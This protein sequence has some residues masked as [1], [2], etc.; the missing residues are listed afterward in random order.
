MFCPHSLLYIHKRKFEQ[1]GLSIGKYIPPNTTTLSS[2]V[3]E[4]E[5]VNAQGFCGFSV[6]KF[7]SVWLDISLTDNSFLV[8]TIVLTRLSPLILESVDV[9]E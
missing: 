2:D 6:N 1:L 4:I 7:G 3:I 9:I 5:L 8:P